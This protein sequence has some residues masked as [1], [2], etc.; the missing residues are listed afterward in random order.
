MSAK[1]RIAEAVERA[2]RAVTDQQTGHYNAKAARQ[3]IRDRLFAGV[4]W[5]DP[6]VGDEIE[7]NTAAKYERQY[8]NSRKPRSGAALTLFDP[9]SVLALGSGERVFMDD[10]TAGDLQLWAQQSS[11]NRVRVDAA[12]DRTQEYASTRIAELQT[13]PGWNLGRL[14]REVHDWTWDHAEDE[15]PDI[16]DD[17]E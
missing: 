15:T 5:A 7:E 9:S 4:T 10:A 6:E 17:N 14:E 3:E 16:D 1:T 11:A 13:R 8:V 12:D 2:V